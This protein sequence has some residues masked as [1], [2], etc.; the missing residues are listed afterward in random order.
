MGKFSKEYNQN[1]KKVKD[2]LKEYHYLWEIYNE[3]LNQ[4]TYGDFNVALVRIVDQVEAIGL[5][6]T[7]F[8]NCN[9]KVKKIFIQ[10][11]EAKY[12]KINNDPFQLLINDLQDIAKA[13]QTRKMYMNR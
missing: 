12:G 1:R 7:T 11:W 3:I 9:E 6:H 5:V 2:L 13:I 8:K 10:K 4:T